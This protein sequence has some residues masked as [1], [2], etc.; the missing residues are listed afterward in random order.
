MGLRRFFLYKLVAKTP[1]LISIGEFRRHWSAAVNLRRW[2]SDFKTGA[3]LTKRASQPL[4]R[5]RC[6]SDLLSCAQNLPKTGVKMVDFEKEMDPA[7]LEPT[8]FQVSAS[9]FA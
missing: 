5:S 4:E 2:P 1:Q 8:I 6:T 3:Q 9:S 7:G